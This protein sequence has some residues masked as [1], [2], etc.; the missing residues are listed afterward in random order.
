MLLS[1]IHSF[2]LSFVLDLSSHQPMSEQAD[3]I[4][5]TKGKRT[6]KAKG[7]HHEA[8]TNASVC[9]FFVIT[10]HSAA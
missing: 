6:E 1:F 2:F 8:A 9:L 7:Q 4:A 3:S 10:S 5:N